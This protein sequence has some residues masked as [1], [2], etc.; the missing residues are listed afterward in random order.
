[1][2]SAGKTLAG[3]AGSLARGRNLG[4]TRVGASMAVHPPIIGGPMI[5]ATGR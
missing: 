4:L 2:L 5:G 3:A 1:V